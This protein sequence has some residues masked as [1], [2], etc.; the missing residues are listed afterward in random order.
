M[1]NERSTKLAVFFP[2]IGYTIEKPLLHYSRKLTAENGYEIRTISYSGFPDSIRGDRNKM[3]ESFRIALSQA[4]DALS[5]VDISKYDDIL[6]FGKSIGTIV[7]AKIA[8]DSKAGN[9]IR[10]VLYTPLDDT[11]SFPLRKAIAFTGSDDPWVGKEKS[12]IEK[13]CRERDIPCRIIAG[14]NHSLE[15]G[16]TMRDIENIRIVMG[17]TE[18]FVKGRKSLDN[19]KI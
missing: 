8:A 9:H 14:G 6:F 11:F 10:F 7:A 12:Q 3:E 4:E 18:S 5:D 19:F 17:D 13:L 16:D 1:A 15:T 2:G